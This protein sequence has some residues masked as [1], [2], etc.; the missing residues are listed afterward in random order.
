MIS[1]GT[2]LGRYELV[3][4]IGAG[5]MGQVYR[6]RDHSLGRF[7]A[8][9]VLPTDQV[10][11]AD[12][13][14]RFINEARA[15]SA[16][17]HPHILHVYE[18][19]EIDG[20]HYIA[21][22]LIEG[23][24]LRE[25]LRRRPDLPKVAEWLSQV[26]DGLAKAHASGIVHRDLKPEN[27]M[28]TG[29]GYAKVLDFGLAKLN[30]PFR[31]SV[32]ATTVEQSE[33]GQVVGTPS[34]MSPEQVQGRPVD[35]RSDVFALGSILFESVTGNRAF[36]GASA[37]DVM[38]KIAYEDVDVSQIVDPDAQRIVRK[39]LSKEPE[40]RYQSTRDL[41]LDLHELRQSSSTRSAIVRAVTRPGV[42]WWVATGGVALL[43]LLALAMW[44]A[45]TRT[46]LKHR[47]CQGPF[48]SRQCH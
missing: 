22:E 16:L 31:L 20:L 18:A 48:P 39:C 23:E 27:I 44:F 43:A 46:A 13:L 42:T 12:R 8:V 14:R 29:D 1:A 19:G 26:A 11:D 34:Y 15:A 7:V 25:R 47:R 6:A 2:R 5:G 21:T 4:L 40:A 41:A 32:T 17:N 37:A 24:T 38:H 33:A 45:C 9:K 28:I 30:E 3:A 35:H 10:G 36:K